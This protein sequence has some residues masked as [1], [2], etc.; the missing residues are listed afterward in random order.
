MT[1]ADILRMAVEAGFLVKEDTHFE[2][3]VQATERFYAAV[4]AQALEDAA[5]VCEAN[6]NR[7]VA[8]NPAQVVYDPDGT[9]ARKCAAR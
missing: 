8:Y 5:K 9:M 2:T 7:M 1:R 4:R 6:E 3:V